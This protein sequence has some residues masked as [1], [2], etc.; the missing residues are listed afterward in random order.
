[1]RQSSPLSSRGLKVQIYLLVNLRR[2]GTPPP[3]H[4]TSI[5]KELLDSTQ[6]LLPGIDLQ[7]ALNR[8]QIA[9]KPAVNLYPLLV[10]ARLPFLLFGKHLKQGFGLGS[11]LHLRVVKERPLVRLGGLEQF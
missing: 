6:R 9:S 7:I 8:G 11:F 2:G 4:S 1:M 5:L 3:C 10:S